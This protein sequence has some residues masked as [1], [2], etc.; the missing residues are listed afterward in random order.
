M[1]APLAL[2]AALLAAAPSGAAQFDVD[3]F[4]RNPG[5][6]RAWLRACQ[7]DR[8][9]DRTICDNAE[10]AEALDYARRLGPPGGG[11]G[12][13]LPPAFETPLFLDAARRACADTGRPVPAVFSPYCRRT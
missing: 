9:V 2:A 11:G 10:R 1:K 7:G 3:W 5:E 8:R 13:P 12:A 6:R 4:S